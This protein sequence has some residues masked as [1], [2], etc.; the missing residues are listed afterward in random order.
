MPISFD[1]E[2]LRKEHGCTLYFETGLWDPRENVSSKQALA[3]NFDKVYCVEI[4]KDWVVL[5]KDIFKSEIENGRYELIQDDSI[6]I[7]KY[8]DRDL[9]AKNKVMFFLDAHV[10]NSNIS[11]YM[12]KCPL[13]EELDAID[14]LNRNDHVI[15]VDDLRILDTPFP[16]G[17]KSYGNIN[18]TDAIKKKILAIN[19]NYKF[20]TL[21]GVVKNDV[22]LAYV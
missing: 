20:A 21:D 13:F 8:F 3:A 17:E 6:N 18:F 2:K 19:P 14:S 10:D 16:W 1:I 12:M 15:L 9:F 4:R 22:L 7:G 11:N 5:G